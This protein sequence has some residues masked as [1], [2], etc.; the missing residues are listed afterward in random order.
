MSSIITLKLSSTNLEN[1]VKI[2]S[3][4]IDIRCYTSEKAETNTCK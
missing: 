4:Q 3:Q 2:L 1:V